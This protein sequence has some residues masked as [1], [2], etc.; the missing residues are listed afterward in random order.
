MAFA[1]RLTSGAV[2]EARTSDYVRTARAKGLRRRRVVGVHVPR[3]SLV[4]VLMGM[5]VVCTL[6]V[7][8]VNLIADLALGALDPR[9]R[10]ARRA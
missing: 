3:N 9:V 6:A 4:P 1:A 10:D 7:D 8:F 5:T 2:L